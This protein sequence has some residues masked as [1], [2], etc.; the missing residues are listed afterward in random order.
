MKYNFQLGV[1]ICPDID[2]KD[3]KL[4]PG[5]KF[6]SAFLTLYVIPNNS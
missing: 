4:L 6:K 1:Y 2:F 3:K 5:P